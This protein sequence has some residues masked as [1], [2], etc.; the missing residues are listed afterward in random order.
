MPRFTCQGL[1]KQVFQQLVLRTVWKEVG[2]LLLCS[3]TDSCKHRRAAR[4]A[5]PGGTLPAYV[6]C[7]TVSSSQ[8]P[9][10]T[11]F[12]PDLLTPLATARTGPSHPN[13]EH[14][15]EMFPGRWTFVSLAVHIPG[16][17][18]CFRC[19][20]RSLPRVSTSRKG[21]GVNGSYL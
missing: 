2:E 3:N 9:S 19:A 14:L 17:G 15:W 8:V 10:S 6:R 21:Q 20:I 18:R 12:L 16:S 1:Q 11:P 4:P 5:W 13:W 7:H